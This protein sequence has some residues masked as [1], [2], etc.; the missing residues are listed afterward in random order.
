MTN[1]ESAG[2]TLV[3]LMCVIMIMGSLVA[4]AIPTVSGY[5]KAYALRGASEDVVSQ[6]QLARQ[7]AVSTD[8]TQT[9]KFQAGFQ[10][11]DYFVYNSSVKGASWNLPRDISYNWGTGTNS[12]YRFTANGRCLDSGWVILQD[13]RGVRDT[14][15]VLQ[16]G[17]ILLQ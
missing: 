13:T 14:I 4:M 5:R 6:L 12:Q 9:I 16:S 17:L 11:A 8:S 1:R 3:E 15:S 2:F 10:G 7:K